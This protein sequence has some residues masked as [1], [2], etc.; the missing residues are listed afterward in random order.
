MGTKIDAVF[1]NG[2][3]EVNMLYLSMI[4]TIYG[5]LYVGNWRCPRF[6]TE[7]NAES[8]FAENGLS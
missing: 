8:T 1:G 3:T 6:W 7:T 2:T 4:V 5:L